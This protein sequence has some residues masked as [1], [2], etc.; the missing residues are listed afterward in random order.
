[1][2]GSG[3]EQR[4]TIRPQFNRSITMDSQRAKITSEDLLF[5]SDEE[6]TKPT[7]R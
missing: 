2:H 5:G 7:V 3:E 6:D 1:M 4:E